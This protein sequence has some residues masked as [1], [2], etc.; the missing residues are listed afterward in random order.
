MS[1]L[2]QFFFKSLSFFWYRLLRVLD[3]ALS[4]AIAEGTGKT[5]GDALPTFI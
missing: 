5:M 1:K 3:F 4:Y 2:Y